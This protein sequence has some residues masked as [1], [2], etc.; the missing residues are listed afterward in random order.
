MKTL[1]CVYDGQTYMSKVSRLAKARIDEIGMM[2]EAIFGSVVTAMEHIR[3]LPMDSQFIIMDKEALSTTV[4]GVTDVDDN[5]LVT[6]ITVVE[7]S[8][9]LLREGQKVINL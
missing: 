8:N 6:V 7:L 9:T 4:C 3:N 2:N 5:K 1:S